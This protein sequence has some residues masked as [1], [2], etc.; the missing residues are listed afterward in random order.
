MVCAPR[1]AVDPGKSEAAVKNSRVAQ[2][3]SCRNKGRNRVDH[4]GLESRTHLVVALDSG[5]QVV[6]SQAKV[7]REF[8][9]D[10]PVVLEPRREIML[11]VKRVVVLVHRARV[12]ISEQQR[13]NGTA[14]VIA[15]LV[16]I[17]RAKLAAEVV[18]KVVVVEVTSERRIPLVKV[19]I[20]PEAH[21]M[22][23][24]NKRQAWVE[25]KGTRVP[26]VAYPSIRAE[27]AVLSGIGHAAWVDIGK[28]L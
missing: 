24:M 26:V 12:R 3:C 13:S 2:N 16:A 5:R 15:S 22:L 28:M 25:R 10:F 11:G 9:G 4:V 17:A 19:D 7:Q 20:P 18:C 14:A 23:A 6:V 8:L 27:P 1:Y 21:G